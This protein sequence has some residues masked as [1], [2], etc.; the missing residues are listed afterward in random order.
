MQGDVLLAQL[1]LILLRER[2]R[3]EESLNEVVVPELSR[4]RQTEARLR[5]RDESVLRPRGEERFHRI[6]ELHAVFFLKKGRV[7]ISVLNL[8]ADLTVHPVLVGLLAHELKGLFPLFD[9]LLICGKSA[10]VAP[11]HLTDESARA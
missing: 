3:F 2:V 6:E 8:I 5:A 4:L 10:V 11:H 7:E 9:H 1:H